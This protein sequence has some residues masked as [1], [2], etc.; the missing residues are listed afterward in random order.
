MTLGQTVS[1]TIPGKGVLNPP[2]VIG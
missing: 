1:S 2:P